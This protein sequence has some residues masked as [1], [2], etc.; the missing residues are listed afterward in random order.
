MGPLPTWHLRPSRPAGGG[1][2]T[3]EVWLAPAL[4]YLPVRLII[5]QDIDTF[6]DL[7]LK[8]A[9]LQAAPESANDT[10][11]RPSP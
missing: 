10:P 2:L 3:A 9:P 7:M 5:R 11:R 6:I 8:G 4:Q 1:D